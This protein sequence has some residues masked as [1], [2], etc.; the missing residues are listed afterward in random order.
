[1]LVDKLQEKDQRSSALN[2][3]KMIAMENGSKLH[4]NLQDAFFKTAAT[5]SRT[6]LP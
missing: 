6:S 4:L 3:R 1:M 2:K 5:N